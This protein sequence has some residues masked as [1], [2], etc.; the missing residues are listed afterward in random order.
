MKAIEAI[1]V[2]RMFDEDRAREFYLDF[3]GF[4]VDWEHRFGDDFPLYMQISLGSCH[5]HLTGHHG[6][7][8]PGSAIMLDVTDLKPYQEALAKKQ[9]KHAR[10]GCD[11]TEWGTLEMTVSDPFGNR[12][13]FSE[14]LQD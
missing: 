11:E 5:L 9:Y 13:T 8:C 7:C 14:R 4:K 10:P 3:L 12:I 1:P 2:L 6:D